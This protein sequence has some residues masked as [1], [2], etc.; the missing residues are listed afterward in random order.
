MFGGALSAAQSCCERIELEDEL[1]LERAL[2]R[3]VT[4][5][6]PAAGSITP[7]SPTTEQA[8]R[9]PEEEKNRERA[10]LETLISVPLP[11]LQS[12]IAVDLDDVL[13][14]TNEA[15]AECNSSGRM[16]CLSLTRSWRA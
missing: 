15:V 10:A 6:M 3:H 2:C 16:I 14:Q 13:S 1:N 7:E 12:V 9:L 4:W 5:T 11:S 8:D